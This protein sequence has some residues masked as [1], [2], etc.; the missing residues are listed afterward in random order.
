MKKQTLIIGLCA[1]IFLMIVGYTSNKDT[2]PASTTSTTPTAKNTPTETK[3]ATQLPKNIFDATVNVPGTKMVFAYPAKGFY[4]LGTIVTT[5]QPGDPLGFGNVLLIQPEQAYIA[6]RS[7]EFIKFNIGVSTPNENEKTLTDVVNGLNPKSI[8]APYRKDGKYQTINGKE[9]FIYE[10]QEEINFWKAYTLQDNTIIHIVAMHK[11][12]KG[13]RSE[14]AD[15]NN[16]KL[17][18]EALQNITYRK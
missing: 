13:T 16:D 2:A 5:Y 1:V 17:F 3:P 10:V 6:D 9:F 15:Q 12:T 4:E 11:P 14:A 8:E 7:S 18:Q